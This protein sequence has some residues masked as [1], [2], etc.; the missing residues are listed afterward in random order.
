MNKVMLDLEAMGKGPLGMIVQIGAIYFDENGNLGES[1]LV[2]IDPRKSEMYGF[3]T[4]ADTTLWWMQQSKEARD[5]VFC[6]GKDI[7]ATLYAFDVFCKNAKEIWSHSNFDFTMLMNTIRHT[8]YHPE[9]I[10]QR[11]SRDITT[12]VSL[13]GLSVRKFDREGIHHN[14]LNDAKHQVKYVSQAL[15]YIK[16]A[17]Q[18]KKLLE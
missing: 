14:A 4:D 9:N 12:L 5:S 15:Q 3:K 6:N 13:T 11:K 17:K 7:Y 18:I 2:N 1:F 8:Q 10:S 16:A